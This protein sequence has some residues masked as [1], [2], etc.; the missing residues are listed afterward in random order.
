M[1]RI[2]CLLPIL[3]VAGTFVLAEEEKSTE[4]QRDPLA[5]EIFEKVDA[6]IKQVSS[7]RYTGTS[8]PSGI[9]TNFVADAEGEAIFE[10]WNGATPE[11]FYAHVKTKDRDGEPVDITAGGNGDM[12]FLIDHAGKKAYADMDPGVLGAGRNAVFGFGMIEFVHDHP[13]DDELAAESVE[14]LEE[15]EVGGEPCYQ[16]NVVYAGGGG[17][18]IWF[19]STNDYLPRRR[20]QKFTRPGA[21]E[22]TIERTITNLEVNPEIA[23]SQYVMKLPS[24]YEQ[25]DDFAP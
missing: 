14:L 23:A 4:P 8:H 2:L 18:S 16:I 10:G 3:L 19:F 12:F 17:E 1:K 11:N 25:I 15:T 13:F 7:V 5:M 9:A 20:I 24:G 6:A 22:G 21:G